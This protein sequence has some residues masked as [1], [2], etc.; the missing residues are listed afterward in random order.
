ME[1]PG[2]FTDPYHAW[3]AWEINACK[4]FCFF[5]QV[6][7]TCLHCAAHVFAISDPALN[8]AVDRVDVQS[9]E[10]FHKTEIQDVVGRA[11]GYEV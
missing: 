8:L 1:V 10:S 5:S 9:R 4:Q 2:I 7:I 6:L 3:N 11:S